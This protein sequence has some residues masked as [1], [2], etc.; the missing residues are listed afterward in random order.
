MM[1]RR[2]RALPVVALSLAAAA[3]WAASASAQIPA[4]GIV[5]AGRFVWRDVLTRDVAGARRFYGELFGWQFEETQRGG[6]PYVI[7]RLGRAPVAG[8]V[9]VSALAGGAGNWL[10]YMAVD[11]VDAA[12]A[13]V[14]AAGGKVLVEPRDRPIA[15][16][17][18][19]TD[20]QN[21]LLGLARLNGNIPGP[22]QATAHH[23]F[24]QEY[25][26]RDAKQALEFYKALAGY[27]SS[28][29]ES[30]LGVEYH[31]LSRSQGVAGL[32][33]LPATT[34]DVQPNWLP[35]V[36]VDDPGSL[37]ARVPGL[38]GRILVPSSPERR[39]GTLVV[40]ADPGGAALALQ[41][42]PF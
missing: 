16:V 34:T 36:L 7:A 42:Y 37:A 18:V 24:W 29:T 23:F 13:S 32:F 10:S 9:D 40:I 6:H 14:R 35:Y 22:A 5:E 15:R 26:A 19:V 30:S 38:G 21:A 3:V 1:Y 2:V 17:A 20:P 28:I 39:N 33:Q 8:I 4:G 25:L 12:V 11:D 31:V 41:K 27:S